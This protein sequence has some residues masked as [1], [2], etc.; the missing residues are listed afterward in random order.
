MR[1]RRSV[2]RHVFATGL[3][4]EASTAADCPRVLVDRRHV[5]R[6]FAEPALYP[7]AVDSKIAF[8]DLRSRV[9]SNHRTPIRT[10]AKTHYDRVREP[11]EHT[12]LHLLVRQRCVIGFRDRL[13]GYRAK[14]LP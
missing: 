3:V 4:M 5:F 8:T 2:R 10:F 7:S 1:G 11:K 6:E 13:G 12:A 9:E 14:N